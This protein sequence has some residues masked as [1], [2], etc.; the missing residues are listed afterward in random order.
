MRLLLVKGTS[1][2]WDRTHLS[3]ERK[4]R[5][6]SCRGKIF[7]RGAFP[8]R[9]IKDFERTL[10]DTRRW[11]IRTSTGRRG[12]SRSNEF[13]LHF[14]LLLF[15][16]PFERS[17]GK[18]ERTT[19]VY[20]GKIVRIGP[21]QFYSSC[22]RFVPTDHHLFLLL[23]LSPPFFSF[24]TLF[25]FHRENKAGQSVF[26][27]PFFSRKEKEAMHDE[28]LERIEADRRE[29]SDRSRR[30]IYAIR[31]TCASRHVSHTCIAR[32]APSLSIKSSRAWSRNRLIFSEL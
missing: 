9:E 19:K 12:G 3:L 26:N 14:S 25:Y 21:N 4:R 29:T 1:N 17:S 10:N 20:D 24:V 2:L 27:D 23:L 13:L 30:Y 22:Q 31:C 7:F 5:V 16:T 8:V 28:I 18:K 11:Q 32:R 6:L 15:D